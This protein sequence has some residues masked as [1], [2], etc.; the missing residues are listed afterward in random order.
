MLLSYSLFYVFEFGLGFVVAVA[1]LS[2]S[3]DQVATTTS[4]L[5][6]THPTGLGRVEAAPLRLLIL[7]SQSWLL[8]LLQR[9]RLHLQSI[10][11]R[12]LLLQRP[13]QVPN[14]TFFYL[15]H[16]VQRVLMLLLTH[17]VLELLVLIYS[18]DTFKISILI[19]LGFE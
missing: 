16:L 5:V 12:I 18:L 1:L 2:G 11:R 10:H 13:L 9:R 14:Q 15:L 8:E 3:H 19:I 6:H 4:S 17:A 7:V